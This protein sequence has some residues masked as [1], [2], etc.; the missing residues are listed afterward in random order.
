MN[1]KNI[2]FKKI[3]LNKLKRKLKLE[4]IHTF[5]ELV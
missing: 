4:K 2:A 3:L 5:M 1:I